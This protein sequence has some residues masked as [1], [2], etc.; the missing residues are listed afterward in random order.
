M[1]ART[2]VA[3][4]V[5]SAAG[6]IG[7]ARNEGYRGEAYIPTEGD[8]PT[9]GFGSTRNVRMGD[10]T[11]PVSAL[12]RLGH[13]VNQ[14]YE[15]ALKRCVHVP[16]YQHEYDVFVDHAYNVGV[17]AFCGST[18]VKRLNRRDYTG[19][20][21]ALLMWRFYTV[22]P[23]D[24]RDCSLPENKSLCGGLWT[25]RQEARQLCLEGYP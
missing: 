5:F 24:K 18:I 3:A 10:T 17:A 14:E 19:A 13:E 16:L 20:C 9:I 8:R 25:R 4:L 21:D 1:K 2:A 11:D 23:G 7:L 6:L 22:R 15:A 12:A